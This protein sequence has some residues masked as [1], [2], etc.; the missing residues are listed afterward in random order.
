MAITLSLDME[1]MTPAQAKLAAGFVLS[2]VKGAFD[3]DEPERKL[4]ISEVDPAS[5]FSLAA[6]QGKVSEN[7]P[8]LIV[9]DAPPAPVTENSSI[10]DK[11][12]L[13]WDGRIHAT[14][15]GQNTDGTW[16]LKRGVEKPVIESVTAELKRLMNIPG[17]QLVPAPPPPPVTA[18]EQAAPAPAPSVPAVSDESV[19]RQKYIALVGRASQAVG[20]GKLSQEQIKKCL[21]GIGVEN[22][23]SLGHR[24]DLVE[25][26]CSLIDGVIAGQSA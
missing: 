22:L 13:P 16:R 17:P 12:G 6:P 3:E 4:T 19:A 11:D 15:K 2:Y 20:A 5:V 1:K 26:A 9:P 14:S 8:H 10:L 18:N 25:V 7:G 24:L 21:T 23:P